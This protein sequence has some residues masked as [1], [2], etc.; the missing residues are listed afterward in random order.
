MKFNEIFANNLKA[1]YN[2]DPHHLIFKNNTF[3]LF[4]I[5]LKNYHL[6]GSEKRTINRIYYKSNITKDIKLI[7]VLNWLFTKD[8]MYTTNAHCFLAD[9]NKAKLWFN[10][11]RANIQKYMRVKIAMN[12]NEL[13]NIICKNTNYISRKYVANMKSMLIDKYFTNLNECQIN[14]LIIGYIRDISDII[15]DCVVGLI[16]NHHTQSKFDKYIYIK[17]TQNNKE[18]CFVKISERIN[19]LNE[20]VLILFCWNINRNGFIKVSKYSIQQL[21]GGPIQIEVTW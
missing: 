14:W 10:Q 20:T 2:A 11:Y 17:D 7:G 8:Y 18:M 15:P 6:N 19:K 9:Y 4:K 16:R 12:S 1:F 3:K 21:C 5:S 13:Y